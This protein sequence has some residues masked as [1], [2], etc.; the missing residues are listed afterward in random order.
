ML[1]AYTLLTSEFA[2]GFGQASFLQSSPQRAAE[3]ACERNI[4][5]ETRSGVKKQFD[6]TRLTADLSALKVELLSA[7][8]AMDRVRLQY[9]PQDIVAYGDN[10]TL[11]R[12]IASC[13]ALHQFLLQI[14]AQMQQQ[15]EGSSGE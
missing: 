5:S 11:K 4:D 15:E 9:S 10:Q 13:G 3:P 2:G 12:V 1:T 6:V 14:Q 8:C 7:Q